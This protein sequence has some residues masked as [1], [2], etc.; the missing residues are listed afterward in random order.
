MKTLFAAI[1][2]VLAAT[3]STAGE[4][5]LLQDYFQTH[6]SLS[7]HWRT[8]RKGG[9]PSVVDGRL[10]KPRNCSNLRWTGTVPFDCA[11]EADIAMRP[12]WGKLNDDRG[13]GWAGIELKG[14]GHFAFRAVGGTFLLGNG[15]CRYLKIDGYEDGKP[16]R[17]KVIRRRRGVSAAYTFLV[18]GK[19]CGDFTAPMPEKTLREGR[20]EWPQPELHSTDNDIE[21]TRVVIAEVTDGESSP[22]LIVNS[23]FEYDQE[24]LPVFFGSWG[25]FAWNRRPAVDYEWV[26]L[27]RMTVD[28]REKH[29]GRQSLR[30]LVNDA[31]T[32]IGLFPTC[33][34][35]AI[36]GMTGVFSLWM[37]ASRP[38]IE[39]SM[40]YG[41]CRK[42]VEVAQEWARYE[43]VAA[44]PF[45]KQSWAGRPLSMRV[46]HP[47]RHDAVLWIDDL[48][49]EL[50]TGTN[51]APE[52]AWASAYRPA[53]N[54]AV[55]IGTAL[56]AAPAKDGRRGETP[57]LSP[58][59]NMLHG[60]ALKKGDT[61]VLPDLDYYMNE[62]KARFR[63]WN[64]RGEL[65]ETSIDLARLPCGTNAVSVQAHGRTWPATV[66]KRPWKSGATQADAF[67]R[68]LRHNGRPIALSTP[69][70]LCSQIPSP[71]ETGRFRD[72]DFLKS[73]GFGTVHF[74]CWNRPDY[75]KKMRAYVD[76]MKA[77]G[78][79]AFIWVDAFGKKEPST[80]VLMDQLTDDNV[81]SFMVLDEPDLSIASD[82]A[83][84]ALERAKARH[85]YKGVLMNNIGMG[86]A[87]GYAGLK[88]DV[89]MLDTYL[90]NSEG[91]RVPSV[92]AAI[93]GMLPYGAGKGC[94]FFAV[95]TNDLHCRQPTYAEELA[96]CWGWI[97]SGGTGISWFVNM[98]KSSGVWRAMVDFNRELQ[99]VREP[100]L[101]DEICGGAG[102]NAGRESF[103][104]V[105]RRHRGAW[106]VFAC[107][108]GDQPLDRTVFTLPPDAPRSGEV[109]VLFENRILKLRDGRFTDDFAPLTRHV[110]RI[111][112]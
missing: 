108:F 72:L 35:V 47:E 66:V 101:S 94:W 105:T 89:L 85:P 8:V 60:Y 111:A 43:V 42:T 104:L 46:H 28:R 59:E 36:E 30:V 4:R 88:T 57:V 110:Y 1:F 3:P 26:Y 41:S 54:D 95:G 12:A 86:I 9:V 11:V 90:T 63:V 56:A 24:G 38:G 69:N 58:A 51:P 45:G 107:N 71:D 102:V 87:K 82:V 91:R 106:Y 99:A 23:G 65:A 32:A 79:G 77:L 70:L 33:G 34:N 97:C 73:K 64:E 93:D 74:A 22:N 109:E 49:A 61:L 50:R 18:N 17:L 48:Q 20:E 68:T 29:S 98:P 14:G 62:P 44:K 75:L 39:V 83:Q 5:V 53:D 52:R 78:M 112:R 13:K 37:K 25:E 10:R 16:V 40:H 84:A 103:R 92:V 80:D 81:F 67:R 7:D 76:Q 6:D 27:R 31:S 19:F 96:Q 2:A 21:V 55:R 15:Y 100:L